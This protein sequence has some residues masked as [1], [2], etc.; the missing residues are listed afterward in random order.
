MNA[1]V[2]FLVLYFRNDSSQSEEKIHLNAQNSSEA[3]NSQFWTRT[4]NIE[5]SSFEELIRY[6]LV[7]YNFISVNN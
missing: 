2:V 6:S 1:I 5:K 7:K 3:L 4:Q